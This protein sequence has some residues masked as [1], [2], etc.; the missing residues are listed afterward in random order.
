[1][2]HAMLQNA[3]P[4]WLPR[5]PKGALDHIPGSNGLPF[6][7]NTFKLLADPIAFS[8]GMAA[9][10]GPIYRNRALGGTGV[11]LL[12]PDANELVLFGDA[13]EIRGESGDLP[14]LLQ[15]LKI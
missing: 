8:E 6:V 12:G 14:K 15:G 9:R 1:M 3:S 5:Q 4:H 7:G 10:Y 13:G 2:S 11:N